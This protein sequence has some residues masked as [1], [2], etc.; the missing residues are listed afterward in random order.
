MISF[1]HNCVGPAN[2]LAAP[3][4]PLRAATDSDFAA[5]AWPLPPSAPLPTKLRDCLPPG[6]TRH[7]GDVAAR[8]SPRGH[9]V[10][11][12][13]TVR[14]PHRI[15][16]RNRLTAGTATTR[17]GSQRLRVFSLRHKQ[18]CS[19]AKPEDIG[20]AGGEPIPCRCRRCEPWFLAATS[21]K[22]M[23]TL[24]RIRAASWTQ[25]EENYCI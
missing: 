12:N 17:A 1:N 14:A 15:G 20:F 16:A 8:T 24:P 4:S 5:T 18:R 3:I 2:N 19:A 25:T 9:I 10:C 21:P 11:H 22:A 23:T 13:L 7:A 6:A